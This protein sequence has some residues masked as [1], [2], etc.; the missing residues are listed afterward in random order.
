M[1]WLQL[2]DMVIENVVVLVK[3]GG[4][5][6]G[7][8]GCHGYTTRRRTSR[9]WPSPWLQQARVGVLDDGAPAVLADGV[10]GL[11]GQAAVLHVKLLQGRA[12]GEREIGMS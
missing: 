9:T 8:R 3:A 6:Y 11:G 12:A 2:E 7:Q 1:P 10:V 4:D 5:F